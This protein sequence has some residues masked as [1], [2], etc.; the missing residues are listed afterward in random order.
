MV[1][2][3]QKEVETELNTL[4]IVYKPFIYLNN[5]TTIMYKCINCGKWKEGC[6]KTILNGQNKCVECA[7]NRRKDQK[8]IEDKLIELGVV[9]K[10]FVYINKN[11]TVYYKCKQCN[12][13]KT[14]PVISLLNKQ[15][16]CRSC[17]NGNISRNKQIS[18]DEIIKYLNSRNIIFKPF[19][20][21]GSETKITYKCVNCGNWKKSR[22]ITLKK[23]KGLCTNCCIEKTINVNKLSQQEVEYRL[24][25]IGIKYK[26]FI[27]SGK[28]NQNIELKCE[29]CGNWISKNIRVLL[30]YQSTF[31]KRCSYNTSVG[32]NEV[33]K[34]IESLGL[35]IEENYKIEG[36]ELD[37]YVPML[38]IAF[39]Y[40]GLYWHNERN[41]NKN[42]HRNKTDF[43]KQHHIKLFHIWEDDWIYRHNVVKSMINNIL[44]IKSK[45]I[46]VDNC[47]IKTVDTKDKNN[48]LSNNC[49]MEKIRSKI[50]LG[51]YHKDELV[52]LMIFN[53]SINNCFI[54]SKF[55]VKLNIE[56]IGSFNL[57]L[58][59][60]LKNNKN[61]ETVKTQID[62]SAEDGSLYENNGFVL[63]KKTNPNYLY[64]DNT[65]RVKNKNAIKNKKDIYR[66][67]DCGK[68]VYNLKNEYYEK[69]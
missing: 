48:F 62:Y 39:E 51:L 52:A 15:L 10:P 58:S 60:F 21:K 19:I 47:E 30:T 50:N 35:I 13:W 46:D 11:T 54:L 26:P 53:K 49:L 32:E 33:K 67:Y 57:L 56:I 9:F 1:K 63:I 12:E 41:K 14:K 68:L 8:D 69:K 7:N 38:K 59:Y 23:I 31:C 42:Y 4:G 43:C 25:R 18:D 40:N 20:N 5:H 6:R 37:I 66:I 36:H 29:R 17:N 22:F 2:K 55:C 27:Y 16:I 65:M 3:T 64:V 24:N 45:Q 28:K 34:Y 61:C 44:Q